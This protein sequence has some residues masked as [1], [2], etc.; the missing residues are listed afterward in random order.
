MFTTFLPKKKMG[1]KKEFYV[2]DPTI[3]YGETVANIEQDR[4]FTLNRRFSFNAR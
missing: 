2:N 4:S 3:K 1:E